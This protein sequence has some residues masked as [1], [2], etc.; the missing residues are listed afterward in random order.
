MMIRGYKIGAKL[1][2]AVVL[3]LFVIG[4]L[5]FGVRQCDKRRSEAAQSRVTTGQAGAAQ[6][7]GRD[8]IGT[9]SN[10]AASA[11]ESEDMSR[12]AAGDIRASSDAGTRSPAADQ[13]GRRAIC[14][15]PSY[16]DTPQCARFKVPVE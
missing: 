8:A 15:R 10:R 12:D 13:A 3:G 16:I 5:T 14:R 7:S 11:Q 2:V 1:I 4:V 6:E 9:V